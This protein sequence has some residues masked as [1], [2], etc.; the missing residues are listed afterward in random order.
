MLSAEPQCSQGPLTPSHDVDS[1]L[2]DLL[3]KE[4][5]GA[6]YYHRRTCTFSAVPPALARLLVDAAGESVV[7][8][9]ARDDHG[10]DQNDFA[11]EVVR[12][13]GEGVL[14]DAFRCSAEL[15]EAE[16]GHGALIGPLVTHLQLTRACNLRCKHCYVDI[17]AKPAPDELSTAQVAGLFE[18]LAAL[19][20]PVV[21]LAGGEPMLRHD[22]WSIL[23][24]VSRHG[25][26]AWLCTNGTMIDDEAA[27]RLAQSSLRGISVSLDGPT[28][29]SHARLRG[30][31][32]FERTCDGIRRLVAAGARDVQIRVTVT[33]LNVHELVDFAALATE[34]GAHKVVFKPFRASGLADAPHLIV[35]RLP[36]MAAIE[37]TRQAWPEDAVPGELGDGMPTRPPEWTKIIPDFGCVGGTT[38]VTITYDGRVV[39]C[40]AVLED[41]DWRLHDRS[42][43]DCWRAAPSVTSWR[44]LAGND[45]CRSCNNYSKCGGGC[46]ARATGAGE[47]IDAPDPWSYC[48]DET[49]APADTG[50]AKGRLPVIS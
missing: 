1:N 9:F 49:A 19:G 43:A 25:I 8:A 27:R 18:E 10:I 4:R 21:V 17:M 36:Y 5:F 14:D 7:D 31:R 23:D 28:D 40:G 32:Q 15:V 34:L 39:G 3:R 44:T 26:D 13:Q 35:D 29:E 11:A 45:D 50:R 6:L 24:S 48:S 30:P 22:F 12:L 47:T 42:F 38:S 37:A 33:P 16:R 41:G 46:R 2:G 20:S